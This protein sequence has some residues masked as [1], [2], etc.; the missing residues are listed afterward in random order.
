M[1][2][3]PTSISV[4]V[5]VYN[6]PR[7]LRECLSSLTASACPGSEIIVVDDGSTDNTPGVAVE[8]GARLFR[9]AKNSKQSAARNLGA[10]HARGD[11]LFF[12]D[13]DVVVMPGAMSRV[14]KRFDENPDLSAVFG[15]YDDRPR[16][17][18]LVSQ[19]RNLLH[20]FVHQKGNP[21]A[22][23]FWA[24]CGAIRRSAFEEIGGFEETRFTGR[25]EDIELGYRLRQARHR[26]LMDK[27][28]QGTHLKRWT[29]R[30]MIQ[31]DVTCRAVPWARL[32]LERKN[33]PHDLN[34]DRGQ[35][36]SVVLTGL[37]FL[38]LSLSPFLAPFR[39][40]LL[41]LSVAG[42]A[43]VI[44][45]NRDL[46]A[47]FCRQRGIAFAAA[48]IPLHLLYYLYGGLSF[49]YAW[50]EFQLRGRA[51]PVPTAERRT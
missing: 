24:G 6:N 38:F 44:V 2:D 39:S 41:E 48:C 5:P 13:S 46:F 32:I 16:A 18:S 27:G 51:A 7:D 47:F 28:L 14:V 26:I 45:L 9:L 23:T 10:R 1:S 25:I 50:L 34:L 42:L 20:H 37:A 43:G 29:L 49:L 22:S 30:S 17:K 8:A 33:A 31:T 12:V 11:I 3:D 4:I 21:E 40:K 35:R 19:Y 36:L 15:S